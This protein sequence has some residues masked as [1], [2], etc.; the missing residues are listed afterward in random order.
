M[1]GDDTTERVRIL[2]QKKELE[3]NGNDAKE[4]NEKIGM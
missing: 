3:M 1:K 2:S 4:W